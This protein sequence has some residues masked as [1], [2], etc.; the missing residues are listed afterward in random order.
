LETKNL[1]FVYR[2]IPVHRLLE[3]MDSDKIS[4]VRH[5]MWD[6]PLEGYFIKKYIEL[7]NDDPH[8]IKP[9]M[10]YSDYTDLRFFLCCTKNSEKDYQWSYYTPNKDGVRIKLSVSDLLN[11]AKKERCDID[12][13]PIRYENLREFIN[14]LT[15]F[16][17]MSYQV[18]N[19]LLFYKR[20]EFIDEQE[21]RFL[22]Q[23]SHDNNFLPVK[24]DPCKV[25]KELLFDP[26][27][28]SRSFGV[29]AEF[30]LKKWP[31]IKIEH[32][33]LYDPDRSMKYIEHGI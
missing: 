29:Y 1:E 27:M 5:G 15:E 8:P 25:I 3:I 33:N 7:E 6:D 14:A 10:K 20:D 11:E 4:F 17:N 19:D 2:F 9:L 18:V 31:Q 22:I 23:G 12:V 24:I 16:R 30:V 26:R 28:P 32:S 21:I 13:K